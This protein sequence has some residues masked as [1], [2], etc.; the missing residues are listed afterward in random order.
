M[1]VK[2]WHQ[3][4]RDRLVGLCVSLPYIITLFALFIVP[5]FDTHLFDLCVC[6][7]MYYAV[8]LNLQIPNGMQDTKKTVE[9]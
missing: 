5:M 7:Y 3:Q 4:S 8:Q 2:K 9:I 1:E 6:M